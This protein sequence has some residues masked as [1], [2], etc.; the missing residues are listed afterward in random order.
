MFGSAVI[1]IARVISGPGL[2]DAGKSP[3]SVALAGSSLSIGVRAA[4]IVT[5]PATGPTKS[6]KKAMI[7]V[8][9]TKSID[10]EA[11]DHHPIL[12]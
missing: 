3:A 11:L 5:R 6:W 10:G 1:G 7:I 2:L 4:P 9:G 8:A 12:T